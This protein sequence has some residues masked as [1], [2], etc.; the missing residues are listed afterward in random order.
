[1]GN[2]YFGFI[3]K[4]K[5]RKLKN[6]P[7]HHLV[8]IRICLII[9]F[10]IIGN[11]LTAQTTTI[12]SEDFTY[13]NNTTS[14]TASG[15]SGSGWTSANG[16]QVRS[17]K[18]E[19]RT[20]TNNGRW[21]TT[22]INVR[23]FTDMT[24][25]FSVERSNVEDDDRFSFR[26][27]L[28][29]GGWVNLVA[30]VLNPN[31]SYTFSIPEGNTLELEA[32]FNTNQNNDR[33]RLDNVLLQ[34]T[35]PGC[36]NVLDYEFYDLVPP[37]NTVDNIPTT[38]MLGRG[39]IGNFNVAALQ[40]MVDPGD[41]DTF[42]I[43]Y[44]GY[45]QI[46]TAGSYTFYTTSDDGSKLYING[47]QVVNNDG[48]HGSQER[49]ETVTLTKGL[50]PI[51][52][53][54]YENGGGEVLE[55]RYQGPGISKREI[56]FSILYSDCA[57]PIVPTDPGNCD[58]LVF[59]GDFSSWY[60][61]GWTGGGDKWQNPT[62]YAF[63]ENYGSGSETI[64]QTLALTTGKTYVLSFDIGTN[65]S[66]PRSSTFNARVGG[67]SVYTRTSDQLFADNGGNSAHTGGGNISNTSKITVSF[68]APSNSVVLGFE[69]TAN[70]DSH[71]TFFL[72]NISVKEADC[73]NGG[74][75][76][77]PPVINATG[78]QS[79][80]PGVAI[81]IVESVS[82]TDP[83]DTTI[84]KVFVQISSNYANGNDVL[85]LTG[86]HPN[87]TGSWNASE[88]KLTLT[89][90]ATFTAFEAALMAVRFNTTATVTSGDTRNF[91]IVLNEANYLIST[92]HYYEY[93]P[94][95]GITWTAA[96][97][98]AAA[99]KFYGLQGYL[100]TITIA[101]EAAL[102]G[103]Q[104]SGAGWIG[105]SDAAVEG[106]WRWVTGP[107]AGTQF[108]SGAAGG[109]TTP[110]F[111]YGNWNNGEPNNSGDEDYAHINAPGTGFD[112]SWN[113]L[114][115]TGA[116]SGDYQP[117]GYLVEYGGM[118]G[119]PPYPQISAV[120]SIRIDDI[121]PTA[122]N[123]APIQVYCS[124]GIPA[125][126]INAVLDEAD[127]CTANPI[128]TF[129][130]DSSNG[131]SNPEIITRTYR[132]TDAAGNYTDVTQTITITPLMI[133]TQPTDQTI[134]AGASTSFSVSANNVNQYR[135]QVSTNG[136]T[137][138]SDL[139]N[140]GDYSGTQTHTLTVNNSKMERNGYL[141][142]VRLSNSN[143]DCSAIIS[144]AA[145]L[146]VRV[147]TVITNKR[148]TYRVKGN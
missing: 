42:S 39:Q 27:R 125:P 59:N 147:G 16:V 87:I 127:N 30:P 117:K 76:N 25:S 129:I 13:S 118:P 19:S 72:D 142:R 123:P 77:L 60:F 44:T 145:V 115:D 40:N 34:G 35:L 126:N 18:M 136:G 97:D 22:A 15:I 98:A 49:S 61:D 26:Y 47:V 48:D 11:G 70:R 68:V 91:S 100:A 9:A 36:P 132:V 6:Y 121:A 38:G 67:N 99:R 80:C 5:T 28:D 89:G 90:P 96:R 10:L 114:S 84:E 105:A 82:I 43:R 55:V 112:G 138:F 4:R 119:D 2:E 23:G 31:S 62:G 130:G 33:Y 29:G 37:G 116:T 51:M 41:T 12:W 50:H 135:W 137:S 24:L 81:P 86:T 146:N 64:Q 101:D 46:A 66:Y 21:T 128:V 107:E 113:D 133:T 85:T 53:L 69:G 57:A 32:R 58:D 148:I 95:V 8:V 140:G 73:A 88:G 78:D 110:P 94:A 75:D 65:S 45:I 106:Q 71:D 54:F 122:S 3:P 143:S 141:Y 103:K 111:N 7:L 134:F 108:W 144:D 79:Y 104:S 52:V 131:G 139:S 63:F 92:G 14:G 93:I 120:T 56:P 20:T 1:M 102:L 124:A 74:T 83:D 17:S 109:N